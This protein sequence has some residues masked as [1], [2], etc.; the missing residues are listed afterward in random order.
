M[1]SRKP[2]FTKREESTLKDA[3]LQQKNILDNKFSPSVTKHVKDA[4]W[5]AI[6]VA[7]NAEN[8]DVV[9]SVDDCKKKLNNIKV[10]AKSEFSKARKSNAQTG[11]GVADVVEVDELTEAFATDPSWVGISGGIESTVPKSS[12]LAPSAPNS[13]GDDRKRLRDGQRLQQRRHKPDDAS[14]QHTVLV[15]QAE[16]LRLEKEKLLLQIKL[17]KRV[18]IT[19]IHIIYPF[20]Y[21]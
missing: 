5:D 21:L 17:L 13:N 16:N 1:T 8:L 10:I 19:Y 20:I 9:R 6:C 18:S 12:P 7:V 11:A 2:N 3:Y 4:A 15:M 14:L